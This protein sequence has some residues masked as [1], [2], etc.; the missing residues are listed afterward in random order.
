MKTLN[1]YEI[2]DAQAR[3]DIV[4]LQEAV[5]NAG[6]GASYTFTNGLT[7]TDGTVSWDLGDRIKEWSDYPGCIRMFNKTK[8]PSSSNYRG[9]GLAIGGVSSN[10]AAYVNTPVDAWGAGSLAVGYVNGYSNQRIK[11]GDYGLGAFAMGWS[12][13]TRTI[14]AEGSGVFVGG[15]AK[16]MRGDISGIYDGS[17]TWG[18]GN[19]SMAAH[20]FVCGKYNAATAEDA[21]KLFIIGNGDS[22]TSSNGLTVDT[23]GNLVTAGTMT[24]TGA[25]YAEYF[26]FEDGNPNREDRMGYLV[27]LKGNKICLANGTDL[28]G[29]TSG[30]KSIIGDAEEM[31][32]HGKYE[33]D[34]FGR[35]V[36]EDVTVVHY[37]GTE[38]E[39]TET[40]HTKK[41]SKDYD[42]DK[43]YV[44]RSKRPEWYPVGLLG[45]VFVR[46]DGTVV[47]GDYVKAVNGIATK[48]DE[49]TNIR[50]LEVISDNVIKVL[51]K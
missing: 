46:H 21:N 4:A 15:Y 40:L 16:G 17:F 38:E 9:V 49:K 13:G 12:D 22:S 43:T 3:E 26:E 31:N 37:E 30:T 41:I 23:A 5:E 47:A 34:E 1:G 27:E 39:Y 35:Y 8:Y 11:T 45:K 48:S 44:P 33:R 50:V 2:V 42:P 25:D 28:L 10:Y 51:I 18:I 32:W 29:V 20:Q 19:Q 7:E 24:P 6:G 14:T 36:Y